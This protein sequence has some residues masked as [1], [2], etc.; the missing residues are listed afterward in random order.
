MSILGVIG[1]IATNVISGGATGLLGVGLNIFKDI[2][3]KKLSLQELQMKYD[4]AVS[5][6][7]IDNEMLQWEWQARTKVAEIETAGAIAVEEQR[8]FAKSVEADNMQFSAKVKPNVVTGFMLVSMDLIR[9][10]IR[11]GMAIGLFVL[12]C[13]LYK[14]MYEI[15]GGWTSLTQDQAFDLVMRIVNTILYLFTTCVTWYYGVRNSQQAPGLDRR[16]K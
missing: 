15:A 3:M 7:K 4:N 1:D 8:A 6:R 14:E 9:A 12:V 5:L 2:S 16:S 10:I 11:P 13:L